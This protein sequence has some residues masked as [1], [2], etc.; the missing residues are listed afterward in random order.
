MATAGR[1]KTNYDE[2]IIKEV[3]IKFQQESNTKPLVKAI[4]IFKFSKEEYEK[5]FFPYNLTYD[6]WKRKDRLGRTL[7]DEFNA[8]K[9]TSYAISSNDNYDIINVQDLLDKH[10]ENPETLSKYLLPMEKQIR[11]LIN[12]LYKANRTI[13]ELEME[14]Q[15]LKSQLNNEKQHSDKMQTLIY[16]MFSYSKSGV[17]LDNLL[18]LG[19]SRTERV[20][21]ALKNAFTDPTEFL[22]GLES[23]FPDQSKETPQNSNIVEFT[24]K[25]NEPNDEDDW[26]L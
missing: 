13:L 11:S 14:N 15:K 16:Q 12:Q 5:G 10:V 24:P 18:N 26:D 20:S 21:N 3:I 8:V 9:K 22:K 6:F 25:K 7:I 4:D 17:T 2:K 1:K 19:S 23:R